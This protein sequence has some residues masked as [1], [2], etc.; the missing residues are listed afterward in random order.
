M[1]D[2][3][4]GMIRASSQASLRLA[5]G[6]MTSVLQSPLRM[7]LSATL[8]RRQRLAPERPWVEISISSGR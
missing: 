2:R 5:L 8:P 1:T 7:T 3:K 4:G 6:P